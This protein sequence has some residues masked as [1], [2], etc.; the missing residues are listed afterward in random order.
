MVDTR[1]FIDL[2]SEVSQLE[3]DFKASYYLHRHLVFLVNEG[4]QV[5]IGSQAVD[6]I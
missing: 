5:T 4:Y 1:D 2:V 3:G 6:G